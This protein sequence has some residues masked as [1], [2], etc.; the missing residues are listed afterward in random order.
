MSY[1]KRAYE[2][3]QEGEPMQGIWLVDNGVARRPKSKREVKAFLVN[4]PLDVMVEPTSPFG[5]EYDGQVT[6]EGIKE[7]GPIRFVGPDP[8]FKRNFYGS[9]KINGKGVLTVE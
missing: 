1:T 7:H 4:E 5:N 9:I 6:L 8:R 2:E 3:A